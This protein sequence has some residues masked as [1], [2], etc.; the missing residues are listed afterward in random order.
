MFSITNECAT[1]YLFQNPEKSLE[2][3]DFGPG[4]WNRKAV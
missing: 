3:V 4:F 2:E 1:M